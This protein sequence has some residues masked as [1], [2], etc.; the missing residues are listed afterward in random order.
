M[1]VTSAGQNF[2]EALPRPSHAQLR[3]FLLF[4]HVTTNAESLIQKTSQTD[5]RTD[6]S[7]L[8]VFVANCPKHRRKDVDNS[9]EGWFQ[10]ELATRLP[11]LTGFTTDQGDRDRSASKPKPDPSH[12]YLQNNSNPPMGDDR[13]RPGSVPRRT[14]A[15]MDKAI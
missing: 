15:W 2:A 10:R 1:T 7:R 11:W 8:T 13:P 12:R 9:G 4:S 5:L 14:L 6:S 3:R